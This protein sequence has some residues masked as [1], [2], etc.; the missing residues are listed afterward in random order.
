MAVVEGSWNL[1]VS[2]NPMRVF[3]SKMKRLKNDLK[4]FNNTNFGGLSAKVVSKRKEL[5]EVQ[6]IVLSSASTPAVIKL[7]KDLS[8][9]LADLMIAEESFFKQKSR[10]SWIQEGDQNTRYF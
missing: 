8:L 9:E 4:K 7:E 5:A 10:I 6:G 2:G 3:H 1:H